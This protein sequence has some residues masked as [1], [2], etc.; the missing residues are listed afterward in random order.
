[1]PG[2]SSPAVAGRYRLLRKPF[3]QQPGRGRL[4]AW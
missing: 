4:V 1:L 3:A 2:L